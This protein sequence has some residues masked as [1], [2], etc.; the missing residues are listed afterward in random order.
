[1]RSVQAIFAL[2]LALAVAMPASAVVI[3]LEAQIDG[4]Q[5]D[6]GVGT[7]STATGSADMTFD[8]ETNEFSWNVTWTGLLGVLTNAHFHGPAVAGVSA[9]VEVGIELVNP[10]IGSE[11]LS[12]QQAMDLLDGMWYVNIHSD[13]NPSGEIRGQVLVVAQG[14]APEPASLALFGVGL[15]GFGFVARRRKAKQG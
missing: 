12:A 1:M 9:G 11:I 5:A 3:P 13:R 14:Q 8:D 10:S 6:A 2:S 15:A 4:A 7:G